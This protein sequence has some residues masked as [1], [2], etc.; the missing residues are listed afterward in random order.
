M[1]DIQPSRR[2]PDEE[3]PSFSRPQPLP[4]TDYVVPPPQVEI[5]PAPVTTDIPTTPPLVLAEPSSSLT[6]KPQKRRFGRKRWLVVVILGLLIVTI[7]GAIG[8]YAWYQQN[9]Q[10]VQPDSDEMV[11]LTI[12]PGS[13]PEDIAKTLKDSQLIRNETAFNWYV[14]AKGKSGLLQAGAY[15][16]GKGEDVPSIVKHLTSGNTDTFSITFLPGATLAE[17]RKVLIDAGFSEKDV[18]VA[19]A[20]SYDFSVLFTGKPADSD[21]E[22]YI[23]GETY[24]FGADSTPE[25]ILAYVFEHFQ[26]IVEDEKLISLYQKQGFTLYQGITLASIIQR[27]VATADDGAQVSQVFQLRLKNGMELGSDVTYQYIADK[28]GQQRSVDLDSP[29]NTRRYTGLPPGPIASPGLAS[30]KAV[31]SPNEGD[32]LYFLSG[33]DDR[34]YFGRTNEEHEQNIRDHCQK[35]CQI[36]QLTDDKNCIL[37]NVLTRYASIAI[38]NKAHL[39]ISASLKALVQTNA[40][41]E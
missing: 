27:E 17:H 16:L 38:I 3:R 18:D 31:G 33:D 29:Y 13:D 15:R 39:R 11:K 25:D 30:L 9:L 41:C 26:Q 36:I 7:V 40:F 14:R 34:T 35:K 2:Q 19:L 32:Y 24:N 20:K 22:G 5:R 4:D 6:V 12:E 1:N 23:Y 37:K 28:T 21:L 10:A 8:I